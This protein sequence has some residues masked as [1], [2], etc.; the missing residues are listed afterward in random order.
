MPKLTV[1]AKCNKH[2]YSYSYDALEAK[3]HV[4]YSYH[5]F[6]LSASAVG[7]TGARAGVDGGHA[8]L[9]AGAGG[10]AAHGA[11]RGGSAHGGARVGARR[12]LERAARQAPGGVPPMSS[13]T[14]D[15]YMYSY[16]YEES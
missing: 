8:A 1:H 11:G 2:K 6:T 13:C 12:A 7:A 9:G 15:Q 10:A 4:M 5:M 3:L 16:E 14:L